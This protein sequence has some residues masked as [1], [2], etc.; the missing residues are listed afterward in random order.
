MYTYL[1]GATIYAGLDMD[2]WIS[3]VAILIA[4]HVQFLGFMIGKWFSDF[5]TY[6]KNDIKFKSNLSIIDE[7]AESLNENNGDCHK[8]EL[9]KGEMGTG[10][11]TF[12]ENIDESSA[13]VR[14]FH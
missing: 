13:K 4:L 9:D 8:D 10:H 2:N 6:G 1:N 14:L 11:T 5:I 12:F 7:D 3:Y